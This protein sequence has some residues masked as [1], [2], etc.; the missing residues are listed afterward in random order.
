MSPVRVGVEKGPEEA[1]QGVRRRVAA[2]VDSDG[3]GSS[4]VKEGL[5]DL[6]GVG[7]VLGRWDR[8]TVLAGMISLLIGVLGLTMLRGTSSA[9]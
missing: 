9:Y 7:N 1:L 6:K 8:W 2:S 5:R 3:A 4:N